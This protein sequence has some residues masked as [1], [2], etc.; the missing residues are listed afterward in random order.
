MPRLRSSAEK[1]PF[2]EYKNLKCWVAS[3]MTI[4]LIFLP[5]QIE[6]EEKNAHGGIWRG[7]QRVSEDLEEVDSVSTLILGSG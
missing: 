6:I 4:G 3:F 7:V 5:I 1:K 2:S